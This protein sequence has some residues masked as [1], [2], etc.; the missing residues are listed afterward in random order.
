MTYDIGRLDSARPQPVTITDVDP[1]TR[2]AK[3]LTRL[4][5]HIEIDLRYHVGGILVFPAEGETWLVGKAESHYYRLLNK[6]PV[7]SPD[8]LIEPVPGQ[9]QIGAT[10]P[11]Q[12][13][14]STICALAPV[15]LASYS[16]DVR[17]AAASFAPG[18]MIFD[19]DLAKPLFSTGSK[20][21]DATGTPV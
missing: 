19:T 7:N 4:R 5:S 17:P 12:L 6:L 1:V 14:G 18:T 11:L 20:W 13:H 3:G 10:G 9:V 8:V 15:V 2:R 16:S 21:V